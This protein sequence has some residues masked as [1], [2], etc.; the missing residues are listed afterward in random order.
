MYFPGNKENLWQSSF[1][2]HLCWSPWQNFSG[3]N[4]FLVIY[5]ILRP[6]V[7]ILSPD[8]NYF[9]YN[10]E[11]LSQPIQMNLSRKLKISSGFFTAFLHSKTAFNLKHFKK[12]DESHSLCLSKIIDYKKRAYVNVL[13]S[14]ISG[15]LRTVNLLKCPKHCC[16]IHHSSLIT[17]VRHSGKISVAKSLC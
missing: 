8:E 13:K 12:K 17:F 11:K 1:F 5:E 2:N 15:H 9:L 6:F 10:K 14:H 3:S 16:N 7:N 4:S